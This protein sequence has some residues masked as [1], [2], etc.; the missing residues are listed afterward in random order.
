VAACYHMCVLMLLYMCPHPM[1]SN[2][3]QCKECAAANKSSP[4][5]QAQPSQEHELSRASDFPQYPQPPHAS[6]SS[7]EQA[8][9][10]FGVGNAACPTPQGAAV[11]GGGR[12]GGRRGAHDASGASVSV[13]VSVSVSGEPREQQL[14]AASGTVA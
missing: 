2:R 5:R 8:D 1:I 11:S 13:S 14:P 12:A 7:K 4:S 3:R 10:T 6:S 9:A